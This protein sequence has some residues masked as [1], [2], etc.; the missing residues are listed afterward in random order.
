MELQ[1]Q[2]SHE[3]EVQPTPETPFKIVVN[4]DV[5]ITT[6]LIPY[7]IPFTSHYEELHNLYASSDIIRIIKS[8][9]MR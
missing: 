1:T 2:Q 3:N 9:R 7:P 5:E 4:E 8:R 6:F